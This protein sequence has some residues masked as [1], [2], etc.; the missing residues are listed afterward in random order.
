MRTK[1]FY[2]ERAC[3]PDRNSY[4]SSDRDNDRNIDED[5][6]IPAIFARGAGGDLLSVRL[7]DAFWRD[8]GAGRLLIGAERSRCGIDGVDLVSTRPR[9]MSW[10]SLDAVGGC[11]PPF[12]LP[13]CTRAS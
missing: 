2:S 10:R 7:C 3:E 6:V 8:R 12:A 5:R 11:F 4:R 9:S 1:G 13:A